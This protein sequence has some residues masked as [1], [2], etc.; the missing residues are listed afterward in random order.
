MID[1]VLRA[2]AAG[3]DD[4]VAVLP[5]L[6]CGQLGADAQQ[7]GQQRA[8]E[9]AIPMPIDAI[10]QAGVAGWVGAD[11]VVELER[12]CVRQDHPVPH[13]LHAGLPVA[14]LAVVA[15][16][17]ARALRDQQMAAGGRVVDRLRH[18][19]DHVARQVGVD[20]CHQR[21]RNHRAGHHLVRRG[22]QLQVA[23]ITGFRRTGIAQKR[24]LLILPVLHGG[25]VERLRGYPRG[26]FNDKAAIY[27]AA[28]LRLIPNWDPFRNWPVIRYWPW[29]WWQ[30]VGFAEAGRVAP[31]WSFG[32]LHDDL[33]W[34]AG[35][36]IRAM[37]GAGIIRLDF[38]TS[39]ESA[40]F[41]VMANQAF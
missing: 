14:H 27:Y 31:S 13:H 5:V 24:L 15:A 39:D 4:A 3:D 16:E 28:E 23:G 7:R 26:R 29:R 35:V 20:A 9:D 19:G 38:A 34:S 21:R 12:G 25:G 40:Q 17:D 41:W 6:G 11:Q 10:L 8:G 32:D 36:G 22:R 33:K 1:R 2:V 30:V 37:I 18:R